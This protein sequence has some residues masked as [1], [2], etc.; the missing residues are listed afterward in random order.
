MNKIKPILSIH[1]QVFSL[2]Q[3][4]TISRGTKTKI[5]VVEVNIQHGQLIA[6]G[7]ATP[8]KRYNETTQSVVTNIQNVFNELSQDLTRQ[9]LHR[10]LPAG[11][12]RNA[13][14]CALWDLE[15]QVTGQHICALTQLPLPKPLLTAQTISMDTPDNMAYNAQT[16]NKP[17]LKIK[18]GSPKGISY[19][20]DCLFAIDR[21]VPESR[22][23]I[24][25]NEGW[26]ET[27]LRTH[28]K[29]LKK[30]NIEF[31]EQPLPVGQDTSL[32]NIDLPFCADESIHKLQDLEK[33]KHKYQWINIKL[34]KTGGL[35]NAILLAKNAKQQ[36]FKIMMGCMLS[37]SLALTPAY[38]LAQICH[39]VDLDAALFLRQD[40]D[41]GLIYDK[42]HLHLPPKPLWGNMIV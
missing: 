38:L 21:M 35:T 7:E 8:Y 32:A 1:P 24:D 4:F 41:N 10:M 40:K 39:I 19:D 27:D 11:A 12:A 14:D 17:L 16:L 15:S 29:T 37:T 28:S 3:Q 36:G 13:I 33:L 9:N 42:N 34:D 30:F 5:E 18:L 20:I 2:Q 22:L 23:I 31:I 6:R 25:V 26:N